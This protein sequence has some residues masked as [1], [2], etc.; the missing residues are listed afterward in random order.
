M[1]VPRIR[2]KTA[3]AMI[4][5]VT[6]MLGY[7][8]RESLVVLPLEGNEGGATL[9]FDLP[10][11]ARSSRDC[12]DYV[13]QVFGLALRLDGISSIAC[14]VFVDEEVDG[15][16][17]TKLIAS[18]ARCADRAGLHL[19][20]PLFRA[21]NGWGTYENAGNGVVTAE[22]RPL[23]ELGEA[24][25][26]AATSPPRTPE[27]VED[28]L[29][30]HT[31]APRADLDAGLVD[32]LEPLVGGD[33]P[34]IHPDD[35]RPVCE[36]LAGVLSFATLREELLTIIAFGTNRDGGITAVYDHVFHDAPPLP[37]AQR[38]LTD[39]F[40]TDRCENG[41]R[42]LRS[43]AR[44]A[45]HE[46][47]AAVHAAIAWLHWA[48][49]HGSLASGWAERALEAAPEMD[50]AWLVRL[51]A[52]E[53]IVAPWFGKPPRRYRGASDQ[54]RAREGNAAGT[55]DDAARRSDAA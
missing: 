41:L 39:A 2:C 36:L 21:R 23:D 35:E 3:A 11:L 24:G 29:E 19:F 8:P 53:G 49:G 43:V 46:Q 20:S 4:S 14:I 50:L 10:S 6:G 51:L 16:P 40:D 15:P 5:T 45:P 32:L 37:G 52:D 22:V 25:R 12:D 26:L 7:C 34:A 33:A 28:V 30:T 9:R 55:A 27:H 42:L 31:N 44:R 48:L 18:L 38:P 1:T 47:R 13:N 17:R 54:R